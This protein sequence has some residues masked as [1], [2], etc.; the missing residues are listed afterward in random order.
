MKDILTIDEMKQCQAGDILTFY[1][2]EEDAKCGSGLMVFMA[3]RNHL[4]F[5][6]NES[7]PLGF[8]EKYLRAHPKVMFFSDY[9]DERKAKALL[10]EYHAKHEVSE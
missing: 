5:F 10:A 9:D 4:F 8:S 6:W 1:M 2:V 7:G 3:Y